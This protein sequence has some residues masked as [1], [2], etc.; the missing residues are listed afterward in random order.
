MKILYYYKIMKYLV[1]ILIIVLLFLILKNDLSEKFNQEL[2]SPEVIEV[3]KNN[4]IAKI[5]FRNNSKQTRKFMIFY[6]DTETP[7]SGIWVEKKI[8]CSDEI[9]TVELSELTGAR[10]HLAILETDG[11]NMSNIDKIIKFGNG[12]PYTPYE[13]IPTISDIVS[14]KENE[15]AML[16]S[17]IEQKQE[18]FLKKEDES[19]TPSPYVVCGRNPIVKY[20]DDQTDMDDIEV[21]TKCNEDTK[22]PKIRKKVSRSLWNEFKNGYLTVDL[23]LVNE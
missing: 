6:I 19:D 12:Q 1:V 2:I 15:K 4:S 3:I 14:V 13:I 17:E 21:R 16:K 11:K 8:E 23:N 20:V 22:I 5:K 18:P 7:E 10:Y 9:C